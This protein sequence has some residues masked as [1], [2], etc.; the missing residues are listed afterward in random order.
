V[1]TNGG[2]SH[3][4]VGK[5]HNNW[6][7]WDEGSSIVLSG[8]SACLQKQSE[9]LRDS[10]EGSIEGETERGILREVRKLTIDRRM[11]HYKICAGERNALLMESEGWSNWDCDGAIVH[12]SN[13][14][15]WLRVTTLSIEGLLCFH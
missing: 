7:F 15:G 3:V 12:G 9:S 13:N 4:L 5:W 10:D 14:R 8:P 11:R 2:N 1:G 6:T